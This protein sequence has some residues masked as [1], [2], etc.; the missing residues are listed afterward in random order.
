MEARSPRDDEMICGYSL[1]TRAFGRR[2]VGTST[3][4]HA[5][6]MSSGTCPNSPKARSR[7]AWRASGSRPRPSS[8]ARAAVTS[9]T[10]PPRRGRG[11]AQLAVAGDGRRAPT[12][13]EEC[14]RKH[15]IVELHRGALCAEVACRAQPVRRHTRGIEPPSPL[16]CPL[17]ARVAIAPP[18]DASR[19]AAAACCTAC[20]GAARAR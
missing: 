1:C 12:R 5:A 18:P 9:S 2:K 7:E 19:E 6:H 3:K 13:A 11:R 8:H 14:G 4:A 15:A 16:R 10:T 20:R 17:Q